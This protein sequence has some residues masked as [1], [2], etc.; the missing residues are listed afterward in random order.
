MAREAIVASAFVFESFAEEP[1]VF[2]EVKIEQIG[3]D[4]VK[5]GVAIPF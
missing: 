2:V 4:P 1:L 3:I 5:V